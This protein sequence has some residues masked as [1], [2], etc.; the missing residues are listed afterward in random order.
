MT[1]SG[2]WLTIHVD[3]LLPP[4]VDLQ[5]AAAAVCAA[6]LPLRA[7]STDEAWRLLE[8]RST[9]IDGQIGRQRVGFSDQVDV[10][11]NPA[12]LRRHHPAVRGVFGWLGSCGRHDR[13]WS[14]D[15]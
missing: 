10:D 5:E 11:G 4:E 2:D 13:R 12:P 9:P 15:E 3:G 1:P 7:S 6:V 8:I 14:K